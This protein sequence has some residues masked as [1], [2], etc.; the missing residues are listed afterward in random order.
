MR[1]ITDICRE[2]VEVMNE[3]G[4]LDGDQYAFLPAT[5]AHQNIIVDKMQLPVVVL[6]R[7]IRSTDFMAQSGYVQPEFNL[8]LAFLFKCDLK[9]KTDSEKIEAIIAKTFKAARLF[10]LAMAAK[11]D[12]IERVD[13]N[14]TRDEAFYVFDRTLAGCI[15]TMKVK[16]FD[17]DGV[18]TTP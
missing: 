3:S 10:V 4:Q 1:A 6:D 12:D 17:A 11:T 9:D 18:C 2:I 16:P 7:P 8:I 14:F 5:K 15:L 13:P